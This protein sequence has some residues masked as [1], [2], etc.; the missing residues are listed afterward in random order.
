MDTAD[1]PPHLS[2]PSTADPPPD[3]PYASTAV[4]HMPTASDALIAEILDD[5]ELLA[6]PLGY[7]YFDVEALCKPYLDGLDLPTL[8]ILR[9]DIECIRDLLYP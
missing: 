8:R 9:R 2:S 7:G 3:F 5:L 4:S 1:P 6:E